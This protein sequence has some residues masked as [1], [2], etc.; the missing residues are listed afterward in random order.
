MKQ[1]SLEIALAEFKNL[2][3]GVIEYQAKKQAFETELKELE[4]TVSF[5][6][7]AALNKVNHLQTVTRIAATRLAEFENAVPLKEAELQ[8][9]AQRFV[10]TDLHQKTKAIEERLE[11]KVRADL[12]PHF[13]DRIQLDMA[14]HSSD[15]ISALNG[16]RV[17]NDRDPLGGTVKYVERILTAY[18]GLENFEKNSTYFK[19]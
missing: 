9:A 6:D 1:N 4:M 14:V 18:A 10:Q 5:D 3:A 8:K 2:G 15:A 13:K 16:M 7:A 19:S 12:A 17:P 11:A